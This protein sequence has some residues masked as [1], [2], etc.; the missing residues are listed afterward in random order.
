M[1]AFIMEC[2]YGSGCTP[3]RAK[4]LLSLNR[5]SWVEVTY[6]SCI[7]KTSKSTNFKTRTGEPWEPMGLA[8]FPAS[9]NFQLKFFLVI[10]QEFDLDLIKPKVPN[11]QEASWYWD[12][13]R[14]RWDQKQN[15]VQLAWLQSSRG[16]WVVR[17]V[18]LQSSETAILLG[19]RFE[20]FLGL[21]HQ[22]LEIMKMISPLFK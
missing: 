8:R 11:H 15:P 12:L 22:T 1:D 3:W 21:Q 16:G 4:L 10:L 19:S 14:S 9:T 2:G 5:R 7:G 18:A 17:S 13:K 6:R 20:S